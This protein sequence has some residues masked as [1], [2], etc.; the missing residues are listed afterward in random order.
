VLA[1]ALLVAVVASASAFAAGDESG[2]LLPNQSDVVAAIESGDSEG[3]PELTDPSAAK[4]VPLENLQRDEAVELLNGVFGESVEGAAGIYDELQAATLLSPHVAVLPE[5]EA[6]RAETPGGEE[7]GAGSEGAGSQPEGGSGRDE[8][9]ET[10]PEAEARKD[11]GPPPRGS[12]ATSR[13]LPYRLNRPTSGWDRRNA[14][15]Q[16]GEP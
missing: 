15:P 1:L 4:G 7:P 12:R 8:V 10:M 14:R 3:L 6:V 16:P 11:T 13:R 5:P 9:A 2:E